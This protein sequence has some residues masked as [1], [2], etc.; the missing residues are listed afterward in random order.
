V[1][2]LPYWH[3]LLLICITVSEAVSISIIVV[4][5]IKDIDLL[6]IDKRFRY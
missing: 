5:D 6:N 2:L 3:H 4:I 1:C